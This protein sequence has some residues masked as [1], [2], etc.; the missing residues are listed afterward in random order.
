MGA[1]ALS[2]VVSVVCGFITY[3]CIRWYANNKQTLLRYVSVGFGVGVLGGFIYSDVDSVVS[4]AVGTTVGVSVSA[5]GWLLLRL[6]LGSSEKG[7][8]T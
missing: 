7:S 8:T 3:F 5:S 2:F 6:I 4:M 1:L